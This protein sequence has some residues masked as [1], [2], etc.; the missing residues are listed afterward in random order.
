MEAKLIIKSGRID[1]LF[2]DDLQK[3][4]FINDGKNIVITGCNGSGK[5]FYIKTFKTKHRNYCTEPYG[6]GNRSIMSQYV[7]DS[8][9]DWVVECSKILEFIK[10]NEEA[11]QRLNE[12]VKCLNLKELDFGSSN[13]GWNTNLRFRDKNNLEI[14]FEDLSS[15]Q[16]K[17]ISI[18]LVWVKEQYDLMQRPRTEGRIDLW[19]DPEN[20]FH[21]SFQKKLIHF[22]DKW[23]PHINF[24]LCTNSPFI[25]ASAMNKSNWNV[26]SLR[27]N[28]RDKDNTKQW[29][30]FIEFKKRNFKELSS[31]LEELGI[32]RIIWD[33][34]FGKYT[35]LVEGEKDVFYLNEIFAYDNEINLFPLVGIDN[36]KYF[37][38]L[39]TWFGEEFAKK[40]LLIHDDDVSEDKNLK[41]VPVPKFNI[42]RDAAKYKCEY[43]DKPH[44]HAI[45]CI[46]LKFLIEKKNLKK[47]KI[48]N[49]FQNL[50]TEK[51][52]NYAK[53]QI[54]EEIKEL[55]LNQKQEFKNYFYDLKELI[56]K[57]VNA[58]REPSS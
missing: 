52:K 25:I 1:E 48:D 20:S 29:V 14:K 44:T 36:C 57:K 40:S 46:I 24:I 27:R 51:K 7:F 10:K 53:N 9:S 13:Y 56:M 31:E 4:P 15:G 2:I 5:S 19:D 12:I 43:S 26:I 37:N 11:Q 50:S 35:V 41:E 8:R 22:L 42:N 18:F 30:N 3:E 17:I 32:N 33:F 58:F 6:Y 49:W 55:D 34:A 45:E 16:K 54:Q 23:F 21:P 39:K 28:R 47:E 38:V